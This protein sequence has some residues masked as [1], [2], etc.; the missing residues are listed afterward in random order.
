MCR[1]Y[2]LIRKCG[3]IRKY[4]L[5]DLGMGSCSLDPQRVEISVNSFCEACMINPLFYHEIKSRSEVESNSRS[6]AI[7][8]EIW[9][10]HQTLHKGQEDGIFQYGGRITAEDLAWL[11]EIAGHL[12][13]SLR[14]KITVVSRQFSLDSSMNVQR[15]FMYIQIQRVIERELIS[16]RED[17]FALARRQGRLENGMRLLLSPI[18]YELKHDEMDCVICQSAF[19]KSGGETPVRTPC[20]H[21]FGQLCIQTWL[22]ETRATCPTCRMEFSRGDFEFPIMR[23]SAISPWWLRTQR[24]SEEEKPTLVEMKSRSE[25]INNI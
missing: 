5:C 3:C 17:Q 11:Q 13:V 21:I 18:S 2:I 19:E 23:G 20:G 12:E 7:A 4:R 24:A 1:E 6:L 15:L 16:S 22:Q 25:L 10:K 9:T 8:E 14:S